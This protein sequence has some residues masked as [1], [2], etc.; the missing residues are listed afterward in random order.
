[1]HGVQTMR[2]LQPRADLQLRAK[3]A[4]GLVLTCGAA[5]P[6]PGV[7]AAAS[8]SSTGMSS[9]S[10]T[11]T[12]AAAPRACGSR[13]PAQRDGARSF[14]LRVAS[15]LSR[16]A[17][18]DGAGLVAAAI[19]AAFSPEPPAAMLAGVRCYSYAQ[20][21]LLSYT[22]VRTCASSPD[23]LHDQRS[24]LL[25]Y[26]TPAQHTAIFSNRTIRLSV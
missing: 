18:M 6:L 15:K 22:I 14:S 4:H 3:S 9:G 16:L 1:M 5:V 26:G 8:S 7:G 23:E 17:H 12:A 13:T 20:S 25:L 21:T 10:G 19:G 11:G 24:I 2:E